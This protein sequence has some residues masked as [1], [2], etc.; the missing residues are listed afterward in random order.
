MIWKDQVI[1][2]HLWAFYY[3][4]KRQGDRVWITNRRKGL[5]DL[6]VVRKEDR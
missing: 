5:L 1:D 3:Y 2:N 6:H 4:C